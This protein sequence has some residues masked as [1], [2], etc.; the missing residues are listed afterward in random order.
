MEAF[1]DV[2]VGRSMP[3]TLRDVMSKL[4]TLDEITLLEVLEITSEELVERFIDKVEN[5]YDQ[6]EKELDD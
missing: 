2:S 1:A 3:L 4:T 6:L 5:K